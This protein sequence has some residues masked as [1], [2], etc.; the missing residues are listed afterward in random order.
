MTAQST[1]T[2]HDSETA[3]IQTWRAITI[4]ACIGIAVVAITGILVPAGLG[5]D[6]ANF[7]DTGR[8]A[9]A[10]Q[11]MNIYD[12][13]TTIAGQSP[14]G[15]MAFWGAP[16]SAWFYAPLSV[17]SPEVALILF[18][19]GGSLAYVAGLI[20]L[21]RHLRGSVPG[22]PLDQTRFAAVFSLAALVYQPF[23]TMYRVGGQTTPFV[24]LFLLL[25]L[26]AHQRNQPI[27]TALAL[28]GAV[29]F[30]PAFLIVPALLVLLSDRRLFLAI[31]GVFG[32]AA[33][34]SV[35]LIG[36]PLHREFIDVLL[37]GSQRPAPWFFN[38]S[39]YI[40]ADA[41][42]PVQGSAPVPGGGGPLPDLLRTGLKVAV[43][44]IFVWLALRSRK[45]HWSL[46]QRRHFNFLLATSFCLLLSQ[47][48]WEHYLAVLFIPLAC[49]IA[50]GPQLTR[51]ARGLLLAIFVVALFQNLIFVM[52]FRSHVA[53]ESN[54]A[55]LAVSLVKSGTLL[56]YLLWLVRYKDLLFAWQTKVPGT[57]F[58]ATDGA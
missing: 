37:R 31:A 17:F 53:I 27:A 28:L 14:Q 34:L 7:Y 38:S 25:A 2:L 16:I 19:L 13:T 47:V 22:S 23:W 45:E 33:L 10:G 20:L 11:L 6:F 56:L 49:I 8:R 39:L 12:P 51:P 48:V 9:A 57:P 43:L 40:L 15:G 42:R 35:L 36:W 29:L 41:F 24:F 1:L 18:K 4:A 26:W 52:F 46:P 44:G 3:Q 58:A 55:L 21:Y 54:A 30:K 50:A 32:A 5:W